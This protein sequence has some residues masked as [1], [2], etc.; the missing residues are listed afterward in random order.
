MQKRSP[1]HKAKNATRIKPV[2]PHPRLPKVDPTLPDEG[3][4]S[5]DTVC[6]HFT[7]SNTTLWRDVKAGRFPKPIKLSRR[8]VAWD[9]DDL[10]RHKEKLRGGA[11]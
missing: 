9:V 1:S 6:A 7:Y 2:E 5:S 4:V 10:R 11:A 3:Y 8:R